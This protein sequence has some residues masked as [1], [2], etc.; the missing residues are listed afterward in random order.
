[1]KQKD[2]NLQFIEAISSGTS[3][4]SNELLSQIKD[5]DKLS[6]VSALGVYSEDYQARLTESL[7][8]NYR[9]I[10]A[11]IGDEDFNILSKDYIRSFNSTSPNLDDYGNQL[12]DFVKN[13]PLINDYIFLSE[14]AHFEWNFREIFHIEQSQGLT[15]HELMSFLLQSDNAFM[16]LVPS[17]KILQYNFLITSLYALKDSNSEVEPFDFE[18]PQFILMYKNGIVVKTQIISQIQANII[19]N[20]TDLIS[21]KACFQNTSDDTDPQE[22]QNL[23]QILGAERLISKSE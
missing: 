20:I 1:M 5:G 3:N 2:F 12:S 7:R 10:L 8:N 18:I 14:L 9:A 23:F 6:A 11:L 15:A 22:I 17:A 13:H 21:L 4:F 16:E 19:K